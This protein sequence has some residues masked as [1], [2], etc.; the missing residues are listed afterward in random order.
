[1]ECFDYLDHDFD[2]ALAAR[3]TAFVLSRLGGDADPDQVLAI[4]ERAD[5]ASLA[6]TGRSITGDR[7]VRKSACV[8]ATGNLHC[9]LHFQ[10]VY[11]EAEWHAVI[12]QVPA[13]LRSRIRLRQMA[14]VNRL[15][16]PARTRHLLL[17]SIKSAAGM[18]DSKPART[19]KRTPERNQ[20]LQDVA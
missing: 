15:G 4:L 14:E 8:F 20:A 10:D 5:A 11:R 18:R 6:S 1:M 16:L 9:L 13:G 3:V 12:E 19:R 7:P 2:V 17:E